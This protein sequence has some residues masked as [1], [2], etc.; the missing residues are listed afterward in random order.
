[1]TSIFRYKHSDISYLHKG[2]GHLIM[3]VH[4]F[5]EDSRALRSVYD[6]IPDTYHVVLPDLP[7]S[8]K[9]SPDVEITSGIDGMA[10]AILALADELGSEQFSCFGHSMGGYVTLAIGEKAPDKLSVFGLLHSHAL[11]DA[12]EKKKGREEGI[13]N[14]KQSGGFNYLKALIPGFFGKQFSVDHPD[15]IEQQIEQARDFPDEALISYLTAMK[16]RPDRR[17]VLEDS[18]VPV[19]FIIG[20]EDKAA[21]KEIMLDQV[22]LPER[23]AFTVLKNSGHMGM[24]EEAETFNQAVLNFLNKFLGK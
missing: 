6:A 14:I 9:S 5:A 18:K 16:N 7:G 19:L 11:P 2:S 4:G 8:G 21:P 24:M 3:L 20:E 17:K 22:S 12:E 1:M 13:E 10:D 23:A 15:T